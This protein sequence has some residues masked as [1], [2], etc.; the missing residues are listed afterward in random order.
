[1]TIELYNPSNK[2]NGLKQFDCGVK[3]INDYLKSNIKKH[4]VNNLNKVYLKID[5]N[6]DVIGFFTLQ[7]CSITK[8]SIQS[9]AQGSL[10]SQIPLLRIS[11]LGVDV[12]HQGN[13]IG[14]QLIAAAID[15]MNK[16]SDKCGV[17][18]I[19][20]DAYHSAVGFY[21]KCGFKNLSDI[22]PN[23]PTPMILLIK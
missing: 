17:Y 6:S 8:G 2:Y 13:D 14:T 20:L 7:A 18:G 1:M 23:Q 15:V 11:M 22:D 4:T 12:N 3:V 10:T 16:V 9:I 5:A 21:Q 19:Y